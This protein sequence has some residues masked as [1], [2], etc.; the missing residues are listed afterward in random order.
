[1]KNKM[2][3]YLGNPDELKEKIARMSIDWA[4]VAESEYVVLV[5]AKRN[6]GVFLE[7]HKNGIS[8]DNTYQIFQYKF[9]MFFWGDMPSALY[10]RKIR[11]SVFHLVDVNDNFVKQI[12]WNVLTKVLIDDLLENDYGDFSVRWN[13]FLA[14]FQK[15]LEYDKN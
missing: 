6:N 12:D 8:G 7:H 14:E 10:I 1:M 4:G 15:W 9:P 11:K 2:E 3:D 5:W 13:E